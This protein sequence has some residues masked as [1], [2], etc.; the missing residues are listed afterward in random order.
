M[1]ID[2]TPLYN[3]EAT[4]LEFAGQFSV[5]DLRAGVNASIDYMLEIVNSATDA[6]IAF[7]P[8]DG[9]LAAALVD[10]TA[11]IYPAL[12]RTRTLDEL[13]PRPAGT[14][15]YRAMLCCEKRD[16]DGAIAHFTQ[17]LQLDPKNKE[18]L[19]QYDHVLSN[20]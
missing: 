14:H 6:Q 12:D 19:C 13:D 9:T 4:L 2:F 3:Q 20:T 1:L 18:A 11:A 8:D 5:D 16:L 7:S 15:R 17:A 10:G